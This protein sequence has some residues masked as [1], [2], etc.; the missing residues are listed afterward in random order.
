MC[1]LL[2][3]CVYTSLWEALQIRLMTSASDISCLL[4]QHI[5]ESL[6]KGLQICP[7]ICMDYLLVLHKCPSGYTL[8]CCSLPAIW[9]K[10][11]PLCF[12]WSRAW[13]CVKP[14]RP[15]GQGDHQGLHTM[16]PKKKSGFG[17]AP[18]CCLQMQ[19]KWE[20]DIKHGWSILGFLSV[21]TWSRLHGAYFMVEIHM[22]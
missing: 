14:L 20:M 17:E 6:G 3:W 2:V 4:M 10:E 18:I 1:H 16:Q 8:G 5:D 13:K 15:L 19:R 21:T 12:F 11:I 7:R 22:D 9:M